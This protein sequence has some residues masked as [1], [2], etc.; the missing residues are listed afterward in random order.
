MPKDRPLP[1]PFPTIDAAHPIDGLRAAS[2]IAESFARELAGKHYGLP[3]A[4]RRLDS[5]RDQNFRL[6]TPD[7]REYVLKVANPAE[8]REVT[9]LQTATLF[10]LAAADPDLPIPRVFPALNGA[11]ELDIPFD[12]GSTRVVR[13]LSFMA[14]IPMHA[15]NPSTTLRRGLGQCAARL[16]RGLRNFSHSGAR[17]KLLWDLQHAAQLR[18]LID[19]VPA[20]RRGLIEDCLG[21]FEARA[22][23]VLPGLHQQPVHNDLNPHNI[24]VDPGNHEQISG[25]IDFGDLTFT[26]RVNDLA[27]AAAY[28]VADSDD[29]F[30]APCELIAAYHAVSALDPAEFDILFDLIATRLVMTVVISSWRAVR[31]PENRNY[32]LRNNAPAWMRLGRITKLPRAAA[33][34]Q[35]R[36][37]RDLE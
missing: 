3:A 15:V 26:A 7:G 22:L 21:G 5:E 35:I 32:I 1:T 13:L 33:M 16:A 14:G 25:I 10:H 18:P 23:P 37:A 12:D 24:V 36:R 20:D 30:A 17:H 19:A 6:Q 34:Q 31:Y 29:P 9:N 28:Q 8:D 2:P 11:H 27:I 4:A